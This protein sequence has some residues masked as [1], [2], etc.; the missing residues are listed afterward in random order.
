MLVVG[1]G[2]VGTRRVERLLEAGAR[3]SVVAPSPTARLAARTDIE[4]HE[5]AFEAA[6]VEGMW[7][8]QACAPAEV[9]AE[10]VQACEHRRVWCV[11]AADAATSPAWTGSVVTGPDGVA[12]AVSGGGDP[13]RARLLQSELARALSG[14][15]L[16]PQRPGPGSVALVGAGPGDPDLLTVR[17][18]D[19]L[20]A[21]DVVVADRLAPRAALDLT[22]GR[23][24]HVGKSPGD[25][26]V[27]QEDINEILVAEARAGCRVVRL[28]GG[29]PFVLGRGGEEL[30]ACLAA[31]IEVEVVPGIT[32]AVAVPAAAGIPVTHRGMATG[33]LVATAH[34]EDPALVAHLAAIPPEITIVLLMG[35]RSLQMVVDVLLAERDP[36]TPCA[37]IERGWTPEQ[38]TVTASLATV[39][40]TAADAGVRAPSIVVVGAVAAL[41]EQFA[42]VARLS[43]GAGLIAD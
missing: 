34:G 21:A 5:R 33:F 30:A 35:V 41:H 28:K 19:L 36:D 39:V 27:G 20:A 31:G 32:S 40:Q 29:D 24:V 2:Q 15:D 18:R 14:I 8:V 23:I 10:V 6:D 16:R 12:I 1:G 17:A 11:D 43:A 25:H 38:R 9:N 13:G 3:V 42:D 22:H 7:L 26:T 37:I 4:L